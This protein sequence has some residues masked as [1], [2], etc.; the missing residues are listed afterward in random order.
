MRRDSGV[1]E[2]PGGSGAHRGRAEARHRSELQLYRS[3]GCPRAP[4]VAHVRAPR[5]HGGDVWTKRHSDGVGPPVPGRLFPMQSLIVV[6]I[7]EL[8]GVIP[9]ITTSL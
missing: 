4:G 7:R 2:R 1:D 6:Q 8:Y 9:S 3:L 5:L